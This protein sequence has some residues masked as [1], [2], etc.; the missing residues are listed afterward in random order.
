MEV[1]QGHTY[2][3]PSL[4]SPGAAGDTSLKTEPLTGR[5][6]EK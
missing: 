1:M 4:R 2:M 6:V 5:K 3:S